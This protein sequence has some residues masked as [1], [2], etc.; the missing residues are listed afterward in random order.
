M[1]KP[2]LINLVSELTENNKSLLRHVV[3]LLLDEVAY[4]SKSHVTLTVDG[5]DELKKFS[6]ALKYLKTNHIITN[7]SYLKDFDTTLVLPDPINWVTVFF[8]AELLRTFSKLLE[9][10]GTI[11]DIDEH[12]ETTASPQN[13]KNLSTKPTRN[14]K[15]P[16]SKIQMHQLEPR[17]YSERKG[18]LTL[19][20]TVDI[21]VAIKGKT[22]RPSK[23][24]Y[25]QC[26]LLDKLFKNV[27]TLKSGIFFRTFLGVNDQKIDKKMEKKIRNTVAEINK[28]VEGVGGPNNLIKIQNKKVFVNSSYL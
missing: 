10:E 13:S 25:L 2:Q 16:V 6:K 4:T 8:N 5:L 12:N 1:E 7:Y 9:F 23:E 27:K 18:V 24:K 19:S 26:L 11:A 17:H 21:S 22:R 14:A 28:K 3:S 15:T 20:P